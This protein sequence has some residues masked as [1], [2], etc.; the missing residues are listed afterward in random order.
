MAGL[1]IG[2]EDLVAAG[3]VGFQIEELLIQVPGNFYKYDSAL[4]QNVMVKD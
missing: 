1:K 4:D 3:D 2:Q